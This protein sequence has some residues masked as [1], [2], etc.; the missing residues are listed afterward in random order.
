L[1]NVVSLDTTCKP[2][3]LLCS[4]EHTS[5]SLEPNVPQRRMLAISE[6]EELSPKEAQTTPFQFKPKSF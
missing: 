2:N 3:N 6:T 4:I 1:S 5:G